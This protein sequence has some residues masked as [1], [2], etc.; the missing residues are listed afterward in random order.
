MQQIE[1]FL[2]LDS[3]SVQNCYGITELYANCQ[4]YFVQYAYRCHD[5]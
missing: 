4:L 3:R 5:H 2:H 1:Q